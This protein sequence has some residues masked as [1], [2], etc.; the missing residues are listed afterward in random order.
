MT[1]QGEDDLPKDDVV[2]RV[3]ERL[4]ASLSADADAPGDRERV[5]RSVDAI[6]AARL[7]GRAST[8]TAPSLLRSRPTSS[9]RWVLLAA[10]MFALSAAAATAVFVT[11]DGRDGR[12]AHSPGAQ[13]PVEAVPRSAAPRSD[14]P[15][16]TPAERVAPAPSGPLAPDMPSLDVSALPSA[17]P[18]PA[19]S[20]GPS[21]HKPLTTQ[22]TPDP[23]EK[24]A[25]ELFAMA[26]DAR[27]GRNIP[28]SRSLY[29][30]LQTAYPRS[31]EAVTSFVTLGR[32]ELDSGRSND[33]LVQ[34]DRYLAA[35]AT[36]LREDAMAG[37]ASALES[38]G[39]RD[40]EK[41]AW[42]AL[43]G[44]YPRSLFAPHARQRLAA[45]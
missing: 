3:V 36:E 34:F 6:L 25:A 40:D 30:A 14:P 41:H 43:L 37:R 44:A 35:G 15:E 32:L 26:N 39:R 42:E 10:A 38:L 12:D 7:A 5:A 31:V 28:T 20:A 2:D 17:L 22:G 23:S 11:R 16:T 24:T 8:R 4:S 29:V 33:A 13:P 27:R 19:P 1:I 9:R 18:S 21:A 45:P